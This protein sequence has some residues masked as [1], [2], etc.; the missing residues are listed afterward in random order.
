MS[1][2]DSQRK[3]NAKGAAFARHCSAI[4]PAA[5][6]TDDLLGVCEAEAGA[7]AL[8]SEKWDEKIP[9]FFLSH[10]PTAIPDR[11]QGVRTIP[12]R[13]DCQISSSGH[14]VHRVTDQT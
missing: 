11:Y 12:F 5:M 3:L 4:N 2:V 10:A 6:F 8:R 14:R 7:I 13:A 1:Y 9:S